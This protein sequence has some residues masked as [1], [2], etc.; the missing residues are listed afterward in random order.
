MQ[1]ASKHDNSK[2]PHIWIAQP[3][4]RSNCYSDPHGRFAIVAAND[5]DVHEYLQMDSYS[6]ANAFVD[7]KLDIR[8]DIF[9][10]I[11]FF[12]HQPHSPVRELL[13]S[14]MAR[15][16]HLRISSV[17][18][19]RD[20]A[21]QSIRFHYDQSN[22]F[23]SQFLDSRMVY[24]A[25]HFSTAQ[26]S[27]EEAQTEKLARICRDL[28]LKRADRLLDIGCGWGGLIVYAAEQYGVAAVGC[29]LSNRQAEF[30]R[31]LVRR[32]GLT[33]CV[34]V[35]V[36]DYRD[37]NGSFDKIASV[38]MF[39][40]VGRSRL[41][42]YFKKTHS[43]LEP[44][45]RF[46]NRGV[47]RPENVRDG[48]ETLFLQKKVFPG[49]ELVQLDEMIGAGERAG[50]EAIGIEDL[51][52]GVAVG[53]P[54][55][56]DSTDL[57]H[58]ADEAVLAAKRDGGDRV[59]VSGDFSTK[60]RFRN[61]VELHLQGDIDRDALVLHFLPEV[62][63]WTGAVVAAEALVRWQH[64]SRGLLLPDSFIGVAESMNLAGPLGRW[65][66]RDA[67]AQ[68][69]QWHLC[70]AWAEMPRCGSTSHRCS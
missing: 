10:A 11:R 56:D 59:A 30:A 7:G 33:R 41:S 55:R 58:R 29:T 19:H 9:S 68:F 57:L 54:G 12:S 63:L 21:A 70:G 18:G 37:L 47:V 20:P 53:I 8:G 14:M 13:F 45:G 5:T 34:S 35:D 6:A 15:L 36:V 43:L 64:P 4:G 42:E 50:F 46:L 22:E 67:C 39:E 62:D 24:S 52:V 40:H 17:L 3:E 28:D 32:K 23:Y 38:G 69:S 27:L 66:L 2:A 1:T 44:G 60:R 25:A 65:V 61:D 31:S 48:P 26:K 49:G 51:G 16:E